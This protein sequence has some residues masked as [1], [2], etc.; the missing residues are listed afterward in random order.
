MARRSSRADPMIRT[1]DDIYEEDDGYGELGQRHPLRRVKEDMREEIG[2]RH[3]HEMKLTRIQEQGE[4]MSL[5]GIKTLLGV[6]G[7]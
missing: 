1:E 3:G 4:G 7:K 5:P 2:E 6:K